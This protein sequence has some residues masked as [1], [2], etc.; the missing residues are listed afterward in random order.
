[1]DRRRQG[2]EREAQADPAG[3]DPG[4]CGNPLGNEFWIRRSNEKLCYS[5]AIVVPGAAALADVFISYA[6]ADQPVAGRLAKALQ[7]AGLDVWWD[8]ELPAHR[9]YSEVIER[10]LEQAKAVVVLW[11]KTAAKSQW[12]RA[13]ADY[14]RNAGKL[15]QAQLDGTLPPMPFNQIQCA[16]LKGWRGSGS[17]AGWRKLHSSVIALLSGEEPIDAGPATAGIW[18]RLRPYRWWAAASVLLIVAAVTFLLMFAT[19]GGERKPVLAVLPFRSLDA[20][21]ASLAAGM[22]EDTR[23]AVG[24][25]PQLI[26]LGPNTAQ[27][28]AEKGENATR[29]A[30]DYLLEASVRSA[31][32]RIRVST[33]LVRTKDGVQVWSQDFDQKL[34]D[35]FALQS[36]IASE[37]EGRI[38]GRLAEEGGVIPEHIATSGEAYAL[39]VDARAKIRKRTGPED[40]TAAHS[41]LEQVLKLDP[42][43]APAWAALSQVIGAIPPSQKAWQLT[44]SSES[45][46]RKAIELAPNLA[47]GHAALALAL[48]LKGPIARAE[49]ERAIELDPNDFEAVTW[50]GNV[51]SDS[52]DAKGAAEAYRRA[53][54]IEPFFW[55]AVFNLYSTLEQLNDQQGMQ[56]L[57]E[58]ENR[59][60]ADFLA[61]A[62]RID[63]AYKAGNLGA[64]AKIGLA[65]W[66]TG[67]KE[68]RA[69]IGADLWIVLLQ[70]GLVDEAAKLGPGPDFA[71]LLWR[72]DPKGLDLMESHRIDAKTFFTLEP[73]TENAGRV[74]LLS[75]RGKRLS[76][77]YLS[78]KLSPDAFFSLT[79]G[80]APGDHHFLYSAPLV[81]LALKENGHAAEARALLSFA[82]TRA[83]SHADDKLLDS[84]LLAR[85]YVGE[86]RK[87]EGIP[88]LASAVNGGWIPEPPELVPDLHSDPVLAPLRGDPRFEAAR[89]RILD[90]IAREREKIDQRLLAQLR[91]A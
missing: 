42:N 63:K 70:F 13:E 31:G 88:L 49:I 1:M 36:R 12:V 25:N 32:D 65:Y 45:Y 16:G 9:A 52:G 89:N 17:Q 61:T 26:V 10:N 7:A 74:Y 39:Y 85:I 20:G 22:W 73:L 33:T 82:E 2:T 38:R 80:D 72:L 34:D 51:R 79:H 91:A 5:V 30:A 81:A 69:A 41:E 14:A 15:V 24:R 78:L 19:P 4:D 50:L 47:A 84:V 21:D 64:A 90:K 58:Q 62:I 44:N 54:Q 55:P 35:V 77:L 87:E 59:L 40:Y 37:I 56:D 57:I 23:T 46:A 3:D 68:G 48:D 29:K 11:S 71:P 53:A 66:Q 76:D 86:G 60:G 75:E 18:D 27:N 8:A 28:L 43:Y 83:K 67:R 6:R